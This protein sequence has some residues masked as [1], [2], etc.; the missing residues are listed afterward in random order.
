MLTLRQIR[1]FVAVAET[2]KISA[3]AVELGI[4]QSAITVSIKEMENILGVALIQR[5]VG[6]ISL[7]QDGHNFLHHAKN[8]ESNVA[9]AMHSM[10][11]KEV[12]VQGSFRLGVTY[13]PLGYFLL[14]M[15][16]RFRRAYPNVDIEIVEM[17]REPL[18]TALRSKKVDLALLVIS[19]LSPQSGLRSK[20][21]FRSPRMLWLSSAHRL[22]RLSEIALEQLES[23]E[24]V[25]FVSDEAERAAEKYFTELDF[26]PRIVLKTTS[27][28]A[29]RGMVA[30]GAAV[31]ILANLV[32]RPWSLDG[33]R[34]ELKPIVE[35]IPSLQLGFA[36]RT[37][38]ELS[39]VEQ[40][41]CNYLATSRE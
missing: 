15:L 38:K 9:D 39:E 35:K 36:W 21:L 8:I 6:G 40:K 2:R 34:V 18:E 14:P 31:T 32:Y 22:N 23:E 4:S 29:V 13:T 1:Y 17:E 24:F 3:A 28:E 5:R 26:H 25:Q 37:D 11:T 10:K 16:A 19:N 41:F 27:M 12:A 30:T 33:G 20:L 7:T